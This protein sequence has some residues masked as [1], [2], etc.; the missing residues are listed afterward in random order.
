MLNTETFDRDLQIAEMSLQGIPNTEI[1]KSIG[2]HPGSVAR[3]KNRP[4]LKALIESVQQ[5]VIGDNIQSIAGT[6]GRLVRRYDANTCEND[7]DKIEKQHGFRLIERLSEGIGILPSHTQSVFVQNIYNHR[8]E[9]SPIVVDL[10]KSHNILPDDP[11]E[12]ELIED[13]RL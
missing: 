2:V 9:L 1:A 11:I 6:I 5:Q 13:R 3:A 12:A 4:A 7:N 8:T 10:L